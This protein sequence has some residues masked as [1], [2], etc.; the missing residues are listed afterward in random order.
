[1]YDKAFV[2]FLKQGFSVFRD[3]AYP[4]YLVLDKNGTWLISASPFFKSG[5]MSIDIVSNISEQIRRY[6]S[7]CEFQM[8]LEERK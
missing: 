5:Q 3:I 4:L 7:E 8:L 6:Q 1:M 2:L